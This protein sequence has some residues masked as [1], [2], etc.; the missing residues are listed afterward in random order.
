MTDNSQSILAPP[1]IQSPYPAPE[2]EE[3]VNGT[4]SAS[5]HQIDNLAPYYSGALPFSI[6]S[7]L[8]IPDRPLGS[9][10]FSEERL[11]SHPENSGKYQDFQVSHTTGSKLNS[12]DDV[13]T[14]IPTTQLKS[15][16]QLCLRE[17]QPAPEAQQLRTHGILI[18][19]LGTFSRHRIA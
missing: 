17:S 6:V 15:G 12:S 18:G 7:A 5:A 2:I 13:A 1:Q 10:G 19:L 3:E 4:P 11:R 14:D 9:L 8:P 16:R